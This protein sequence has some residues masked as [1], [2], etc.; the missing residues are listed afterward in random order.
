VIKFLVRSYRLAARVTKPS[1]FWD[2]LHLNEAISIDQSF[3]LDDTLAMSESIARFTESAVLDD[4]IGLSDNI[5]ES[6]TTVLAD[7][8]VLSDE[9]Q[10]MM[11]ASPFNIAEDIALA[12]AFDITNGYVPLSF[13]AGS[14]INLSTIG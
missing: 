8:I 10:I 12:E 9:V 6:M 14:S 4:S 3:A 2:Y 11:F 7:N 5:A 1:P 13:V